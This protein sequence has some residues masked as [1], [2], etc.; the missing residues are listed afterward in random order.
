MKPPPELRV[1]CVGSRP[2]HG[3]QLVAGGLYMSDRVCFVGVGRARLL[4]VSETTRGVRFERAAESR[5]LG[6]GS[7]GMGVG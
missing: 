6:A 3:R 5:E 4:S 7:C 2:L 1:S